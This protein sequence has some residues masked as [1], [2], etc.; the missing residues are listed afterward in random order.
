LIKQRVVQLN[1]TLPALSPVREESRKQLFRVQHPD[2]PAATI[3][4]SDRVEAEAQYRTLM[5]ILAS[6][7]PTNV[8]LLE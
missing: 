5:G 1:E 7:L 2:S 8:Q 4:A 3:E 6:D